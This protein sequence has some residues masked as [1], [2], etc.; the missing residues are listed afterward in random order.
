MRLMFVFFLIAIANVQCARILALL[1]HT[2]KSH[3]MVF[4]PLFVKLAERGHQLTVASFFP[5]KNS[6]ANYSEISFEG[7]APIGVE[8]VDANWFEYTDL[9]FRIPVV[10]SIM[11][12]ISDISPLAG[13]A[14]NVCEK[15][16]N[17]PPLIEILER[18]YDV[19]LV[20]NFNSDCM[21]GLLHV[22]KMK[23]PV[24]ALLTGA[25][26]PWSTDRVGLTDNPSYVPVSYSKL[27]H[28]MSL[29]QKMENVFLNVYFKLWYQSAI[30]EKE[31]AII[32]R[33]YGKIV[34]L[35]KLARNVSLL[36]ANVF[37]PLNGV[38]P[39]IPG[40]VEV[41]GMHLNP[42][43]EATIPYVIAIASVRSARIL[44]LLPHLGK[45]HHMVYEP[46]LRKLAE[47]GH[48]VT[49]A[50][51]FPLK[52]PPPNYNDI[53]FEGLVPVGVE[54][55]DVN[56]FDDSG[57]VDRIPVIGDIRKH[58][59]GVRPLAG[60]ALSVCEKVVDFPPL[61]EALKKDYDVALVENFNSDCMLG[62]LS[63]H[64]MKAPIIALLTSLVLPW[65]PDRI[66]IMDN[67]SYVPVSFSK[68]TSR[69]NLIQKMQN[70]FLNIFFKLWFQNAVQAT[71]QSIIERHYGR[72]IPMDQ[73]GR[74]ISLMMTNS[75]HQ[76]NGVRPTV[77]GLIELG[78]LH[79]HRK[80]KEI[81]NLSERGHHVT[82]A[83]FFPLKNPP[84]NYTDVS[85]EGIANIGLETFDVKWY[86]NQGF[87][88]KIPVV[89]D[90]L[91]QIVDYSILAPLAL[92]VCDK[93]V[94]WPPLTEALKKNYDVVL[95]EQF[96]SD[97]MLG[98]LHVYG[99]NVP[100][101]GLSSCSLQTWTPDRLGIADN[102][103]YL[104][105]VSTSYIYPMSFIERVKNSFLY[106]YFKIWYRHSIQQVE[107]TIIEN[108]YDVKVDLEQLSKSSI[109]IFLVNT[110]HSLNGVKP[111]LPSVVEVGG[112]HLDHTRKEIPARSREQLAKTGSDKMRNILIIIAIMSLIKYINCAKILGL[113]PHTGK[114]HQMVFEPLLKKLSERGHHVTVA[115]F[116]P[117]KNPPQNYSDV[118]FE[119]ISD[120]GLETFDVKWYE[121]QGFMYKIPVVKDVLQ[122]IVDYS[123]LAPLA[124]SVCDKA[125]NWPPLT[126]ALKKNYDVVLLEQFDSDCMLGLLHVYGVNVPVI[127]LSSST[128]Q[129]WTPDR[130]GIADNPS[131]LPVVSTSY[132][133]PMSFIERVKNSFLYVYFKIWYRHSIQQVEQT[134]IENQYDV[135]VDLEQLSKSS[136]SILLVNT[137]HAINGVKPLLP[138]VVEVGGMHLDH[139]RKEI[140]ALSEQG[141]HVTVV[142]FFPLKN[143]PQNYTDVS[144]EGISDIGLGTFDVTWFENQG[145][146]YKIPVVKD[147]LQQIVDYSILA[148]FALSV[149][150][151]AVN[152][153]PLT[154]ALKKKYD[155]VLL[156]QF[157]S[158]CMLGLLHVYG[159]NVPVIGLSSCSL[160]TWT[161]DRL[162]IADNPSYLPVVSTSYIYPM[163]IIERV[164]NS[165]LYVYFKIWYRHSIQQVE[166]T[167]I[168]N[169]Y[170]VKVNLE[171]LSKSSI[172]LLLVNTFHAINGVKPLL[173]GVVEVGGMHLDHT[174]KEIP[175]YMERFL[176]ESE[177]GVV[178]F[179]F[180]S[181]IRTSTMPKYK[182][183]ILVNALSKLKQR[184]IWKY[185]ES[186]EEG[187]L[188]GNILRVRWLPQYELL[189]H[190]KVVAFLAHGGLLG[191]TE[192]VSAGKP[193]VVVPFFGDQPA[194]AA[195][196]ANVG[197]AKVVPY[198][199]LTEES[200]TAALKSVLSPEE[201]PP[202]DT[203]VYWVERVI[204]WGPAAKLHSDARDMPFYQLVLLD[205]I[206]AYLVLI[207]V[208]VSL[209][210][211]IISKLSRLFIRQTKQKIQ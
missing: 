201:N 115:S 78:G 92:S 96:N 90:V 68:F 64:E 151:K 37:H 104:P 109:S 138:G 186:G 43:R 162:G 137:F 18:N 175:V 31:R 47:R 82:V 176:N 5:L 172:S 111:L 178:L 80:R 131:Y 74:N 196:A 39:L 179:S 87:M 34:P 134:I 45:S 173:P 148:P 88:Y 91:Q 7:L 121:N 122:Q 177:H 46:L 116:F 204:R 59:N 51:F 141:H 20:E 159:V 17:F 205:V 30:Q 197:F 208:C 198:N 67:P 54:I 72:K 60:F 84:V 27:L 207:L 145:F 99:V 112:M 38:R 192:A 180:G 28:P 168:E 161:S 107:Q 190:R 153:P 169:Q 35:D 77:P 2:G 140:P 1:P 110:F 142:S 182:E 4:E 55:I 206:A 85:F 123:I 194:N 101:I 49:V 185:E 21:L 66:G 144:F 149:C 157:N 44:C 147:V 81:P 13:L 114:S 184:V 170:D 52:N 95:L 200:L 160:Q 23:A 98:L 70:V 187:T 61:I 189:Q 50:S 76:L 181:L 57:I 136:I 202:L 119:G 40:L 58:I 146:I 124:L 120:I 19:I 65:S 156:E 211:F 97:C 143:P 26:P 63:V 42:V 164:K 199:E 71:E 132:I 89:K 12:H 29:I 128:L 83:S 8:T 154:E 103:S 75:F 41:G 56:W 22:Y 171:Q 195:A 193:M 94:N 16:V 125:V 73:L 203:A 188:T 108:Q 155:V 9:L 102:P 117:L 129:T 118:S 174:R 105:V 48:Q 24:I 100:V 163:S 32:E 165:F 167:F 130:L 139:T 209:V 15:V 191:M 106:V 183:E 36:L 11:K 33:H 6:P 152:W 14:L 25:L 158:D 93:A 150:E 79:L 3:H 210:W 113:F 133:Y 53:S 62:L 69:M 166:Q 10:G 86:E 135:K 127:G 126:E